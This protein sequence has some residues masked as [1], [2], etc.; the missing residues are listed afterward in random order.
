MLLD[1]KQ[2]VVENKILKESW[3]KN[4]EMIGSRSYENLIKVMIER[5]RLLRQES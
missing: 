5:L 4:Y 3:S 2:L 1:K